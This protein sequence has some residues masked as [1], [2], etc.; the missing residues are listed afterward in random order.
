MNNTRFIILRGNENYGKT[1][2][3]AEIYKQLL[4]FAEKKHKF[5]KQNEELQTVFKD[6]VQK[7][8]EGRIC[9]FQALL[10]IGDKHVGLYSMGDFVSVFFKE[11]VQVFIDLEV[12]VFVC[13][14]RS[15]NKVNSTFRYIEESYK[16][17]NKQVFWVEYVPNEEEVGN[18]KQ[19]QAKEIVQF[20][21]N[22]LKA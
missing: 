11:Y 14:T 15:R 1:T 6:S 4:P 10:T 18:V 16:E 21:M 3:C 8:K 12:D 7:D 13:C 17:F 22:E 2:L 9:D 20:I 5:G 19:R